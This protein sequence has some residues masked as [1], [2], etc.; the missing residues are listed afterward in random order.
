[1]PAPLQAKSGW[2]GTYRLCWRSH[3]KF[4]IPKLKWVLVA[5]WHY[6]SFLWSIHSLSP[7][8]VFHTFPSFLKPPNTSPASS[9]PLITLLSIHWKSGKNWR[10]SPQTPISTAALPPHLF[11][12]SLP[13]SCAIMHCPCSWSRPASTQPVHHVPPLSPTQ[14]HHL[15][16]LPALSWF[17]SFSFSP[18]L[19]LSACKP[20]VIPP[21]LKKKR[22]LCPTSCSSLQQHSFK[23]LFTLTPSYSFPPFSFQLVPHSHVSTPP[24]CPYQSHPLP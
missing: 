15:S 5:G 9:S 1:M 22:M 3:F 13:L 17:T 10:D 7:R 8:W 16:T 20:N 14:G 23:E 21:M 24:R 4:M 18:G 2:R 19:L 11:L 12:N 6:T